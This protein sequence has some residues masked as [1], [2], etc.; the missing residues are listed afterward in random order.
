MNLSAKYVYATP[1][2]LGGADTL[3]EKVRPPAI[4][5]ALRFWWRALAWGRI[6][7]IP[8]ASKTSSLATL[9]EEE[10]RLFGGATDEGALVR[11]RGGG[12][13]LLSELGGGEPIQDGGGISD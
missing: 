6:Q 2:F 7:Q 11:G 3:A 5:G 1:A 8:D 10:T 9:H 4:K 13:F 12:E